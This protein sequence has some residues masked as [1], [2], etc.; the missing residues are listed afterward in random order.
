[1]SIFKFSTVAC[2]ALLTFTPAFAED[3]DCNSA[4]MAQVDTWF[5]GPNGTTPMPPVQLSS[6]SLCAFHVWSWQA[7]L[8]LTDK[9]SSGQM[10]FLSYLDIDELFADSAATLSASAE[11]RSGRTLRLR[12]RGEKS[13]S[14]KFHDLLAE[15]ADGTAPLQS[16][17]QAG[18]QGALVDP[19]GRI[20]YYEQLFNQAF[21]NFI[22]ANFYGPDPNGSGKDV[23]LPAMLEAATD[24]DSFFDS[25]VLELKTSWMVVP[26]GQETTFAET[27]L[28]TP[29][30]V[31]A[32][33]DDGGEIKVDPNQTLPVTV[34]L[35]GFHV[36]GT[37]DDHPEMIWAT[38][39]QVKNAPD[40]PAGMSPKS[41]S[42]VIPASSSEMFTFY[43]NGTPARQSN[44]N[45]IGN[46][47]LSGQTLS[48]VTNVFR[49]FTFGTPTGAVEGE[50]NVAD[51]T[52]L[53]QVA[54]EWLQDRGDV[55]WNYFEVGAIWM[56]PNTLEPDQFPVTQLRGST[57]LSNSTIETFT[58]TDQQCFSCH[59]TL[60]VP[61]SVGGQVHML[62]GTNFNISH[63]L[64][65]EWKR[66]VATAPGLTLKALR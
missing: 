52:Y 2:V 27:Y 23:F 10:N 20:I 33:V 43:K 26:A 46:L 48:P 8:H 44:V 22:V 12:P 6:D 15:G 17:A 1:M 13:R 30:E 53:N 59:N 40:L 4:D 32:L 28:T 3:P 34:A 62:P 54:L 38:F 35:V 25:G 18:S 42:P 45:E 60:P 5:S 57:M 9:D 41:T 63:A 66:T 16:I 56:L 31:Y 55:R 7:F 65:D 14:P 50:T 58:Q 24:P 37:V 47:T 11:A 49:E 19:N 39:E 51:I 21:R 29:A 36:A 64:V 61:Y